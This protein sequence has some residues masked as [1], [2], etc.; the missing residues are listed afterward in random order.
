MEKVKIE[1]KMKYRIISG[2]T[3]IGEG[4]SLPQLAKKIGC[5]LS[6]FYQTKPKNNNEA[7]Y[8]NL[9]GYRYQIIK[10]NN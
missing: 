5:N 3:L 10:I 8:F 7:W 9:K 1:K 2:D 4:Y 6:W